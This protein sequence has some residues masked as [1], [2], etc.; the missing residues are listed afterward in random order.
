M[1]LESVLIIA[2]FTNISLGI[3]VLI[4][5]LNSLSNKVFFVFSFIA[6]IWT[7]FDYMTGVST[8]IWW[9]NLSYACG[10][11]VIG[12]GL[13]WTFVLTDKNISTQKTVLIIASSISIF[14]CSLIPGSITNTY[15]QSYLAIIANGTTG[16][17]VIL[18]LFYYI[19]LATLIIWKLVRS[20]KYSASDIEKTQLRIISLGALIAIFLSLIDS[21]LPMLYGMSI[22]GIDSI[23]FLIFQVLVLYSITKHHFLNIKVITIELITFILWIFIIIRIVI[24]QDIREMFA[25]GSLLIVCIVFGILLIRSTLFEINQN[26]HI[27]KLANELREAYKKIMLLTK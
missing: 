16:N 7:L 15:D 1:L 17:G 18:Y 19:I 21:A 2:I 9:M 3:F 6:A 14:V 24:A 22:W 23:G 10:S 5:D 27:E 11:L 25:E 20:Q 8:S 4:S 12:T 26:E 13:I